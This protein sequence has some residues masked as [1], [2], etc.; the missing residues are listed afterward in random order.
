MMSNRSV[1]R[2]GGRSWRKGKIPVIRTDLAVNR[3]LAVINLRK[4]RLDYLS[5]YVT[6]AT[7]SDAIPLE[8]EPELRACFADLGRAL[9]QTLGA[10]TRQD[11]DKVLRWDL[12][13]VVLRLRRGIGSVRFDL[14]GREYQ[15]E[16]D[17]PDPEDED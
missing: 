10:P 16:L 6:D 7:A 12:S 4:R 13:R 8:V 14:V 17:E 11:I 3:P 9:T 15:A 5:V 1:P 2:L